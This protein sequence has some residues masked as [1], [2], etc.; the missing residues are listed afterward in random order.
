MPITNPTS[1]GLYIHFPWCIQKCPY[2][3]FNSHTLKGDLPE[4]QYINRLLLEV[5][6]MSQVWP[7]RQ[8]NS[9]FMGGG[10]PSLFKGQ[11]LG[12]LLDELHKR[13]NIDAKCEITIEANPGSDPEL[14]SIRNAGIN[15]LSIGVQSFNN[16]HLKSLGRIH[17]AEHAIRTFS[18]ARDAGFDNINIDIMFAL[19]KQTTEELEQDLYTAIS[20]EPDHLSW[21]QLTLEPNTLFHYQPPAIPDDETADTMFLIGQEIITNAGLHQYEISAYT[22]N[23]ACSHNINYWSYG[24]YFGI[25]AGAHGKWTDDEIY[26]HMTIKHPKHYLMSQTATANIQTVDYEQR[27]FEYFLNRSR[28]PGSIKLTQIAEAIGWHEDRLYEIFQSDQFKPFVQFKTKCTMILTRNVIRFNNNFLEE[29]M[30]IS[31]YS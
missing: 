14:K 22:R 9:I 7:S 29:I 6:E 28:M 30:Q 2:C 15:R 4:D 23:K 10:T 3:D 5:E 19:I 20:L 25:G 26:R 18:K 21:Y 12:K 11:S 8:I 13:L 24:D 27:L 16:M 17:T 1:A 31:Q